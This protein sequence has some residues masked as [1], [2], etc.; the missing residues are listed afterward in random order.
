MADGAEWGGAFE[1]GH[2]NEGPLD[3]LGD[4]IFEITKSKM[5]M[6]NSNKKGY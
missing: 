6:R 1:G 5:Q 3:L 2:A 4:A